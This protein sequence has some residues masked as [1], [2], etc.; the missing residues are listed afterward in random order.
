MKIAE[1]EILEN[2]RKRTEEAFRQCEEG[3]RTILDNMQEVYYEI[4]L[5]GNYIFLNEA[6]FNHLGYRKEEMIG[7]NSRQY[8][9]ETTQRKLFQAYNGLYRTGEPIKAVEAKWI[10]KDGDKRTYEISASL[11]RDTEGKPVGLRGVSRDIT[12]RKRLE[13]ERDKLIQDIRDALVSIKTLRGLLPI[14]ANCR[15]I[16]DDKGYRNQI[17]SYITRY[18]EP[19]LTH[20]ICPDCAAI[21]Y[22]EH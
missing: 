6:I 15:K 3:Y 1:L 20:S 22:P 2:E 4:D 16:M 10:S 12:E 9:D 13:M 21:L 18:S 7:K 19:E 5:S 17:K 8:Q 11:T 14:C